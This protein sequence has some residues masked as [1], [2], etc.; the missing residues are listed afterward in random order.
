MR[1]CLPP[2]PIP[3]IYVPRHT[4]HYRAL[5]LS[6]PIIF[7]PR[8]ESP[9]TNIYSDAMPYM[10]NGDVLTA[11]IL[12][13]TFHGTW[14]NREQTSTIDANPISQEVCANMFGAWV[15][16]QCRIDA[17]GITKLL[18]LWTLSMGH[19]RSITPLIPRVSSV[20]ISKRMTLLLV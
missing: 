17:T 1:H 16:P 15:N 5:P 3:H 20:G 9:L 8:M 14:V 18:A 13:S 11:P 19:V 7:H 12:C 10:F 6:P 2:F 4:A